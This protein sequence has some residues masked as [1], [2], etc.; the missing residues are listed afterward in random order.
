MLCPKC[1]RNVDDGAFIC[2]GCDFI[3]DTS[4]LGDDIT[5]DERHQRSAKKSAVE[6]GE[7]AMILGNPRDPEWSDFHSR[8]AG[9]Q[10]E[11]T[12]ARFYVGGTT[13]ALLHPDAVP[14]IVQEAM[15]ASVRLSPFERHVLE[16]MNG[17]RSIGR[18]QKK[19]GMEDSEFKTSVAMLSDKGFI[20]LRTTKRKKHRLASVTMS[21]DASAMGAEAPTGSRPARTAQPDRTVVANQADFDLAPPAPPQSS[22]TEFRA[23]RQSQQEATVLRSASGFSMPRPSPVSAVAAVVTKETSRA[24]FRSLRADAQAD[25]VGQNDAWG[26]DRTAELQKNSNIFKRAVANV[27]QLKE[28]SSWG[29]AS[30]A[31]TTE[32]ARPS[33]VSLAQQRMA[34]ADERF[35]PPGSDDD[36]LLF[37]APPEATAPL[38]QPTRSLPP[39]MP[40]SDIDD[41]LDPTG[42]GNAVDDRAQG[43]AASV[44]MDSRDVV[45]EAAPDSDFVNGTTGPL[46][47]DPAA[48][49]S[50]VAQMREAAFD[51]DDDDDDDQAPQPAGE[52]RI[53]DAPDAAPREAG[54]PALDDISFEVD[55][56][57]VALHSSIDNKHT[58]SVPSL[59]EL[60]SGALSPL[61]ETAPVVA[62]PGSGVLVPSPSAVPTLAPPTPSI[63]ALPGQG[64]HRAKTV[65]ATGLTLKPLAAPRPSASSTVGF[66]QARKAE[67]IFEQALKDQTE[68]R[69]SSARMNAKLATQFDPSVSAYK[70]F[71]DGLD[72]AGAGKP[73]GVIKPRELVL[74]EEA[75][76]AEGRGDYEKAADLLAKAI[77]VNPRA[78]A[79]HNRLGVVL[80]IRLKRH[81]EALAH[82]KSA[83]E[84]EPGSLVYMNNFSKVAAVLESA[85]QR[86]PEVGKKRS[87]P[88]EKVD[89]KKV[90]PKIY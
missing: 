27:S 71:L 52:A 75:S 25:V 84:L 9:V 31:P 11:V 85:L 3:L 29:A 55:V 48:A 2:P 17:K 34:Q 24:P 22:D 70:E 74:F 40:R 68:G 16:F 28:P 46:P 23:R 5:D 45:D 82:L 77:A 10:R 76:Q 18:I 4:F 73:A 26:S 41:L 65:A 90:R 78:A 53:A 83:I 49:Q 30:K 67:R 13:A 72:L 54:A 12:Q 44:E 64:A 87:K 21:A 63:L 61:P 69:M 86:D 47:V 6:F 1:G 59:A 62:L 43:P 51:G 81:D 39:A 15:S 37:A 19:S 56:R 80:S 8:D 60:S 14:E 20:R 50:L 89:I 38:K 57:T 7:D 58:A 33:P 79:L 36:D 42:M 35:V 66:E 88:N 32:H